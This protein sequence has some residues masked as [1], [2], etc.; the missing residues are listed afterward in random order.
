M[1]LKLRRTALRISQEE[2]ADRSGVSAGYIANMET[3]RSFPSSDVL[4][5]LSQALDVP[6]WDLLSD[7]RANRP[8][9]TADQLARI[10][11]RAKA[12]VL[13]ELPG[14]YESDS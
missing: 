7:P 5:R 4:L 1:N 10:M 9:L 8:G 14:G 3:G 13:R 2:L 12:Y 6:H 11:D